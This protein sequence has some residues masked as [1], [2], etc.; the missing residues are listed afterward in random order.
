MGASKK[1]TSTT[2]GWEDFYTNLSNQDCP[3]DA[4][5]CTFLGEDNSGNPTTCGDGSKSSIVPGTTES[6]GSTPN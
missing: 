1:L 6:C 4:S 3:M 5:S 2:T